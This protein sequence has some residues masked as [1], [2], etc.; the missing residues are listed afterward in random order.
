[1]SWPAN[2]DPVGQGN[3]V[4]VVS[5]DERRTFEL[6]DLM[7]GYDGPMAKLRGL[8]ASSQNRAS[9]SLEARLPL[10]ST[11]T[12]TVRSSRGSWAR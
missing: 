2:P 12:A 8:R 5:D 4:N 10:R 11:L 3:A 9:S 1:M 6:A 7:N